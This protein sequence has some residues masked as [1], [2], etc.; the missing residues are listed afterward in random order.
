MPILVGWF[1]TNLC[2]HLRRSTG[3]ASQVAFGNFGAIIAAYTFPTSD[4]PKYTKGYAICLAFFVLSVMSST[5]YFVALTVQNRQ[6]NAREARG[7]TDEGSQREIELLGD[8]SIEYRY[9]R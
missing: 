4:A 9:I 3:S 8:M 1:N 7:E 5:A 6:R 2:G